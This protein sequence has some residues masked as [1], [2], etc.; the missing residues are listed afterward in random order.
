MAGKTEKD[1]AA[2][3]GAPAEIARETRVPFEEP[4]KETRL[5]AAARAL[6]KAKARQRQAGRYR[7]KL[8]G[9]TVEASQAYDQATAESTAAR[10][11]LARCMGEDDSDEN[12]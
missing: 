3:K 4:S 12:P 7:D 6:Q 9:S 2:E 10:D 5:I 11:A 1:A 8:V